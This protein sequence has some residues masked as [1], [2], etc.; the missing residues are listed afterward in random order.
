MN[1]LQQYVTVFE[2]VS[3]QYGMLAVNARKAAN[4]EMPLMD[5]VEDVETRFDR[6][7]KELDQLEV[8]KR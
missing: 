6:I 7:N 5:F 2:E 3:R 4:L 8:T 1:K